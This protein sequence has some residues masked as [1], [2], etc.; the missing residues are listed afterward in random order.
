MH[1]PSS[2]QSVLEIMHKLELVFLANLSKSCLRQWDVDLQNVA[3]DPVKQAY[4]L[5]LYVNFSYITK[6]VN[7]VLGR[8]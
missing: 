7:F 2:L 5:I 6:K 1:K 8:H 4:V 3:L